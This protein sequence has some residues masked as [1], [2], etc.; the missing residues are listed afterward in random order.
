VSISQEA[1]QL[2]VPAISLGQKNIGIEILLSQWV[3]AAAPK[4]LKV[5]FPPFFWGGV[6]LRIFLFPM[7]SHQV[8]NKFSMSTMCFPTIFLFTP[9]FYPT[10][11]VQSYSLLHRWAKGVCSSSSKRNFYF[12][13]PPK[14]SVF[15]FCD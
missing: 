11:F 14:F 9:H 2:H 10:C 5:F 1:S 8:F 3:N 7:C 12:E 13:D 15:C 4:R 6:C